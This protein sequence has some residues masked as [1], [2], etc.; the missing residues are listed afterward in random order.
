MML[1]QA[2]DKQQARTYFIQV[3]KAEP[4]NETAWLWLSKVMPSTDQALRCIEHLLTINPRHVRARELHEVLRV[5]LIVEEAAVLHTEAPPNSTMWRRYLLG[6]ALVEAGV[7]TEAQLQSV[8]EEQAALAHKHRPARL[9]DILLQKN[10]IRREHLEAALAAQAESSTGNMTTSHLGRIGEF[11]VRQKIITLA[12]LHL[13]LARQVELARQGK[14]LPIGQ[15]LVQCGYLRQEQLNHAL[16]EW[17][18]E[19][20]SA[21][22]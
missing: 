14:S 13:A 3:L 15:I 19:Y 21:F 11:L 16:L 22:L 17:H 6:Q 20:D 5:R 7:I 8:L 4:G 2:G 18:H 9:G 1:A 12:Q 10:L